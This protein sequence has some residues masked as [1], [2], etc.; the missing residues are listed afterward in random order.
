[1]LDGFVKETVTFYVF[2][3]SDVLAQESVLS[4]GETDGVLEFASDGQHRRL[5]VLQENRHRNK[6]AGTPQL[7]RDAA[8]NSH[9]GIIAA[10]Q[11]VTVMHEELVGETVQSRSEEH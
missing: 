8:C 2:Q 6:T 3:I 5:I 4:F 1:M 11:D 10:Q 7:P 9:H